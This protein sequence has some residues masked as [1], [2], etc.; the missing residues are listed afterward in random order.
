M[1]GHSSVICSSSTL[2]CCKDNLKFS[3][4]LEQHVKKRR[5]PLTP[6]WWQFKYKSKDRTVWDT[7]T[8]RDRLEI[9]TPFEMFLFYLCLLTFSGYRISSNENITH[10]FL[11]GRRLDP[12]IEIIAVNRKTRSARCR[13]T[14]WCKKHLKSNTIVVLYLHTD[15]SIFSRA[16]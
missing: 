11:I 14:F 13:P 5:E 15:G 8:N 3:C 6:T 10:S 9:N 2:I 4:H 7:G 1:R 12:K 16:V